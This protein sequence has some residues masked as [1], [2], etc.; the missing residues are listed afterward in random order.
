LQ[1]IDQDQVDLHICTKKSDEKHK[2]KVYICDQIHLFNQYSY[3]VLANRTYEWKENSKI[4]NEARQK[5][6]RKFYI[7]HSI[8]RIADINI[9][10]EMISSSKRKKK[11]MMKR[12]KRH[13]MTITRISILQ[14]LHLFTRH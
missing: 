4:R 5:I 14:I 10:N 6:Q 9:L 8:K 1:S 7:F 3:I 11:S 2:N 12:V 13:Q